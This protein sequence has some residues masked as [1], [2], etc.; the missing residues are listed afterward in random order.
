MADLLIRSAQPDDFGPVTRLLERLG[1][2][3]V[4][5]R[6]RAA[7]KDVFNSQLTEPSTSHLVAVTGRD[8][9]IGFYSVH[10]RAR[11]NHAEPQAWIHDATLAEMGRV[12]GV[13][14]A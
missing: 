9:V 2:P 6:N 1:R 12:R 13:V 10:F 14:R 11:P 3:T 8:R 7:V 4:T 5:P